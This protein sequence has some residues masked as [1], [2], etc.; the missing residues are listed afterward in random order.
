MRKKTHW[1]FDGEKFES[2]RV[3]TKLATKRGF[4]DS[5]YRA[6]FEHYNTLNRDGVREAAK[7]RQIVGRGRMNKSQL[8][9]ALARA[10]C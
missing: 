5:P 2:T 6:A 7:E 9:D 1:R 3:R 10:V 8:V 4:H